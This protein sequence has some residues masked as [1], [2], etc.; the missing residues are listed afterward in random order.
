M[1]VPFT[2]LG[3]RVVIQADVE[4]HAPQETASGLLTAKTLSAAVEG[5]DVEDSWFVGTVVALGPLVNRFDL[6]SYLRHQRS[7]GVVPVDELLALPAEYPDPVQL[8]DRVVFSWASG[9]QIT[10]D[11]EKFLIMPAR[12]VLAVLDPDESEAA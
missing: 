6:R 12:D 9:Q 5:S 7:R 10:I 2:P 3:D 8:G 1:S 4:D 11:G